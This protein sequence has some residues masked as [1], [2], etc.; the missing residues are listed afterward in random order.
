MRSIILC[1]R[2]LCSTLAIPSQGYMA[3]QSNMPPLI[4]FR[5]CGTKHGNRQFRGFCAVLPDPIGPVSLQWLDP[6]S[7]KSSPVKRKWEMWT[8]QNA[9][10]MLELVHNLQVLSVHC[11]SSSGA[12]SLQRAAR[13][14]KAHDAQIRTV[15]HVHIACNFE[16]FENRQKWMN[17]L[18]GNRICCVNTQISDEH[19]QLHQG[20]LSVLVDWR[21]MLKSQ[22]QYKLILNIAMRLD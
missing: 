14:F 10:P 11:P 4:T 22:L 6:F 21:T 19:I 12:C 18:K 9:R 17:E 2:Y 13:S 5:G 20:I 15:Q 7:I 1:L 8:A 3:I 16:P